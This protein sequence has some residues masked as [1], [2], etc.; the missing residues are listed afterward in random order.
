MQCPEWCHTPFS[1]EKTVLA[2]EQ[3]AGDNTELLLSGEGVLMVIER[4]K[5]CGEGAIAPLTH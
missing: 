3:E 2:L 5:G 4:F 1:T